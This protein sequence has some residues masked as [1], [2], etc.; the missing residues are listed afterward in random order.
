MIYCPR[1]ISSV[2]NFGFGRDGEH[3]LYHCSLFSSYFSEFVCVAY[4]SF[5]TKPPHIW[6]PLG[7]NM[8]LLLSS[9]KILASDIKSFPEFRVQLSADVTLINLSIPESS[10]WCFLW[11]SPWSFQNDQ[12]ISNSIHF[13]VKIFV[14]LILCYSSYIHKFHSHHYHLLHKFYQ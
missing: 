11:M 9:L 8:S 10:Y 1:L 4:C 12:S 5:C 2:K 7:N 6:V 14:S 13:M 3:D